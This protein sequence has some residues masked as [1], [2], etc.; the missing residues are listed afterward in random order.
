MKKL[1]FLLGFVVCLGFNSTAQTAYLA[2][3]DA[4]SALKNEQHSL[5]VP[6][7]DVAQEVATDIML[8][9]MKRAAIKDMIVEIST[10][11]NSEETYNEYFGRPGFVSDPRMNAD[12]LIETQD[13]ILS[14]ITKTDN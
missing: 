3:D 14:L 6:S 2:D 8:I 1:F 13:L 4:I 7:A 5:I 12:F 11:G 10:R 9:T